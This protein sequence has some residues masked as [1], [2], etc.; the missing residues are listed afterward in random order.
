MGMAYDR[1]IQRHNFAEVSCFEIKGK[2]TRIRVR[3]RDQ[4]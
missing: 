4:K 1:E 3:L 2:D